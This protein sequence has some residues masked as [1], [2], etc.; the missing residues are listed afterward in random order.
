[1]YLFKLVFLFSLDKY[2]EVELLDHSYGI[3]VFNFLRHLCAVFIAAVPI[4]ISITVHKSSLLSTSSP[5]FVISYILYNSH[6]N[7]CEV[8]YHDDFDLH[9]PD[10]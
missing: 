9:F 5:T 4:H 10:K 3:S 2:A 6:S 1:M 8:I 7:K